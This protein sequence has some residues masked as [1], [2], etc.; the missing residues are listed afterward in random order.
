MSLKLALV[1]LVHLLASISHILACQNP[2]MRIIPASEIHRC[3]VL[4]MLRLHLFLGILLHL[5]QSYLLVDVMLKLVLPISYLLLIIS[6]EV[7]LSHHQVRRVWIKI[8]AMTHL[9]M[10]T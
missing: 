4:L 1:V 10:V 6:S 3:I 5:R 9:T 8:L 2:N 7:L